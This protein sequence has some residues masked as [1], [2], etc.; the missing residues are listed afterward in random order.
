MVAKEVSRSILD[1]GISAKKLDA[2]QR[3][4]VRT[5]VEDCNSP[6]SRTWPLWEAVRFGA[7]VHDAQGW[8]RIAE[9]VGDEPCYMMFNPDD[10]ADIFRF[11]SGH[12]LARVLN[13]TVGFEFYVTD[14][15]STFLL[16]FNHHD[17]L[18]ANGRATDWLKR[19]YEGIG[20]P[21]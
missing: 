11:D 6:N 19:S 8:Q 15:E 9:Y 12:H 2:Q 14:E 20:T 13:D 5:R 3:A 4:A 17:M 16:C 10:C 7:S 18:L 1:L 21:R